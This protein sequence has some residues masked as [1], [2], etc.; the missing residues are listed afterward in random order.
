MTVNME[1]SIEEYYATNLAEYYL[2][3]FGHRLASATNSASEAPEEIDSIGE[4][5]ALMQANGI[6]TETTIKP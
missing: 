1:R 4:L 2:M 5:S 3:L 6:S